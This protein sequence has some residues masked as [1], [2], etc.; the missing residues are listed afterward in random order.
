MDA[1]D[2]VGRMPRRRGTPTAR[3][4][5]RAG[6]GGGRDARGGEGERRMGMGENSRRGA[7]RGASTARVASERRRGRR[8]TRRRNDP[9]EGLWWGSV[10]SP[11]W[12]MDFRWTSV[13]EPRRAAR[14]ARADVRE[15]D[16]ECEFL[17]ARAGA[18]VENAV[19]YAL[20]VQ[21][22]SA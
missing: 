2:A 1:A 20:A 7:A 19:S 14:S 6:A 9:R 8:R 16:V 3:G 22:W 5:A 21:V 10:T 12:W 13:L 4:R 17:N 18:G 11:D 15:T